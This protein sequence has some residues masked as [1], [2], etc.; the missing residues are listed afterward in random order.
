MVEAQGITHRFGSFAALTSVN[1]RLQVGEIHGLIGENGAGKSTLLRILSGLIIPSEGELSVDG[2]ARRFARPREASDAGIAVVHQE[3][4][5]IP[6]LTV[7]ENISLGREPRRAGLLDRAAMREIA[8]RAL[9]RVGSPSDPDA[10]VRDLPLAEQQLVEIARA[11]SQN[12][13]IIIFD[14]PTA[15]LPRPATLKLLDLMRQL[16]SEGVGIA[17]VS[18]HLDEIE[19][20]CDVVTVLRDGQVVKEFRAPDLAPEV[21]APAM[22]GRDLEDMYPGRTDVDGKPVAMQVQGLSA[23]PLVQ[24]AQFELREG[25]ILGVAGLVGAGRTELLEAIA[26]LRPC[27]GQISLKGQAVSGNARQ[28]LAQG[29]AYV[30]EDRKVTG[31][32][33]DL[34]IEENIGMAQLPKF[35]RPM[36]NAGARRAATEAWKERLDI[37]MRS[38]EDPVGSLSGGNQQKVALAKWLEGDPAVLLLDEPTRGV[39]IG[40]K[41]E[42]YKVI[43]DL[44]AEGRACVVASSE[45]PELIGL[46][47]RILV[48]RQGRIVGEVTGTEMTEETILNYAAGVETGEDVA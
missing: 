15:V 18:H 5:L 31:L 11:M 38:A 22:V 24:G 25:E 23:P 27:S 21:L 35:A 19:A 42:I 29:I 48:M 2:V 7:I 36:L 30:P 39:D 13:R 9:E 16:K 46:C 17:F 34:S 43:A 26:G 44:A 6:D 32:H 8:V 1:L 14:E 3:L 47:H 10:L 33:V 20:V 4:N 12:A 41:A 28:R 40:A 37:K 45:M